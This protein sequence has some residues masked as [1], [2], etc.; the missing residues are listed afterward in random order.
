MRPGYE[1]NVMSI[2][3]PVSTVPVPTTMLVF[4]L[5]GVSRRKK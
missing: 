2:V 5:L 1:V 3:L 4:A